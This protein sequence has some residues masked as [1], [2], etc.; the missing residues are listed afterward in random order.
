MELDFRG[1][2]KSSFRDH[3]ARHSGHATAAKR[4]TK[5]ESL[6]PTKKKEETIPTPRHR[7]RDIETPECKNQKDLAWP[8]GWSVAGG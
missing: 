8:A 1:L 5:G 3:M 4:E 6:P 7:K 2:A